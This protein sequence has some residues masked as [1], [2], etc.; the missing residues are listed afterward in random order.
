MHSCA[1]VQWAVRSCC[2]KVS[3]LNHSCAP[4]VRLH[5]VF[6]PLQPGSQVPDDGACVIQAVRDLRPGD[7]LVVN[8]G[9]PELLQWPVEQRRE[10]LLRNNGFCCQCPRCR[11]EAGEDIGSGESSKTSVER[12]WRWLL[13][14]HRQSLIETGS[15]TTLYTA[16][17][18]GFRAHSTMTCGASLTCHA[19]YRHT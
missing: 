12:L 10:Y 17:C 14:C 5:Q 6:Q 1:P 3:L 9:M 2:S 7:A 13:L 19:Q 11:S 18:C 8:Y 15:G 16:A 4:T